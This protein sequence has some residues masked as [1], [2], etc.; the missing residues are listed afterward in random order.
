MRKNIILIAILSFANLFSQSIPF[1]GDQN[2]NSGILRNGVQDGAK[3]G[4]K[5]E[6]SPFISQDYTKADIANRAQNIEVR[7]NALIDEIEVKD[8]NNVYVL[9]K[10]EEYSPIILKNTQEEIHYVKYN[11][12]EKSKEGY[13]FFITSKN[14]SNLYKK[15]KVILTKEKISNNSYQES[16]PARYEIQKPEFF[17]QINNGEITEFP[18]NKKKLIEFLPD[19]KEAIEAYMKKNKVDFSSEK[20]LKNL[21]NA[22][23]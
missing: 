7:Y 2:M 11:D 8:G 22:I 20:D 6:G 12:K 4:Y 21:I 15:E 1:N 17:I 16:K 18:K 9:P 23:G 3:E 13:L 14:S 19:K 10:N 5:I